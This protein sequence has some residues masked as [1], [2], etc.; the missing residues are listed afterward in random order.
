[1]ALE[2]ERKYLLKDQ[3]WRGLAEGIL[4]RQG[5]LNGQDG[6]TLRVRIC[7]EQAYLTI[8][9]P[10]DNGCRLEYEYDIPRADAEEMLNE[11]ALSPIVEKIRHAIPFQG[12]IWEVDEFLGENSGLV[13][14]EIEL[15]DPEHTFPL[16]PWIGREVTADPRFYNSNLA[17]NPFSRWPERSRVDSAGG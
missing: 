8:K 7:G 12:Y 10:T 16:P 2:I 17:R 15:P 11:L 3:S 13:V 14:A 1:M 5:Y 9:G 6:A 4:Y